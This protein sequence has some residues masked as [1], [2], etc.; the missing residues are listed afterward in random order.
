VDKKT[1]TRARTGIRTI[2]R[3]ILINNDRNWTS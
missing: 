3:K 1:E 2:S